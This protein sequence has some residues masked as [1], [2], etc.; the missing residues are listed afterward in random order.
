MFNHFETR[1]ILKD[2]PY[3]HKK[4]YLTIEGKKYEGLY[5][6]NYGT[7]RWFQPKPL[8]EELSIYNVK[9]IEAVV[10]R[11]VEEEMSTKNMQETEPTAN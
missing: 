6:H 11:R 7:L 4:F 9:D 3:E 8:S 5:D 10:R 2:T 1:P